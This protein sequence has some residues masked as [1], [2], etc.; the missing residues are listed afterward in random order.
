MSPEINETNF[1]IGQPVDLVVLAVKQSAIRCQI[2]QTR[3]PVTWRRV[4]D[5]IEGQII[6]VSPT[7]IWRHRTTHYMTGEVIDTRLDISALGLEPLL[8]H[9]GQEWEPANAELPAE[10]E[11]KKYYVPII[12]AGL[13]P[14][15][16]MEQVIPFFDSD[17]MDNDPIVLASEYYANGD[18]ADAYQIMEKILTSDLRC[19]DAHAHLGN[20][21]FNLSD[22]A[23]H[24][25][26]RHAKS[27]YEVGV[28][29]GELS[30]QQHP[31]AV[32]PWKL[33]NNRPLLR[34]L[35]GYGL[36]LWRLDQLDEA[37]KV[38][39]QM[40]FLNPFDNQGIR[41]LLHALDSG[42]PWNEFD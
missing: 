25:G 4:R 3:Q 17:D 20:W 31:A 10:P 9:T 30:L 18:Q 41:F 11:F 35:C 22:K 12:D 15:F 2:L 28:K 16:E 24:W 19:L 34:C 1:P 5:E 39:Q 7:K 33:T 23:D 6:T 42:E 27:H 29:I 14:S 32:L 37:K 13:R 26:N 36:S 21:A 40:L 38:F 8:L